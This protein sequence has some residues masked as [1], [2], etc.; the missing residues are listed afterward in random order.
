MKIS[1]LCWCIGMAS[2]L[3]GCSTHQ[4]DPPELEAAP[5]FV[6]A[7]GTTYRDEWKPVDISLYQP[8]RPSVQQPTDSS[9]VVVQDGPQADY[10][11]KASQY[12][13][14][15]GDPSA[16]LAYLRQAAEAGSSQAHYDLARMLTAGEGVPKNPVEASAHLDE[17]ARLGN[18]EAVRVLGWM[19]LRG[20]N[21]SVDQAGGVAMLETAATTSVRAQRELG[22]LYADFYQPHLSDP[23]RAAGYLASA[24]QAGD[25][26]AAL[27]YGKLL[28]REG[29]SLEAVAPLTFAAEKGNIK[30]VQAL[31]TLDGTGA[32]A[33]ASVDPKP[34]PDDAEAMYE[35]G[36]AIMLGKPSRAKE[37]EAYA[38]FSLAADR[39]HQLAG[40]EL[41]NLAGVKSEHDA[42]DPGWLDREKARLLN[43]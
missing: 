22:M 13:R 10:L 38:W 17:A 16:A 27:Y 25:E 26:E 12:A 36:S 33:A 7:D 9:S 29:K 43:P 35:K 28:V 2:L 21:G 11:Y 8:G 41:A 24:Y 30:A 4:V 3:A 18:A 39:G 1:R 5:Q 32:V 34:R 40:A 23:E 14:E 6:K 19:R 42:S 31:R 20:D 15:Q 37:A